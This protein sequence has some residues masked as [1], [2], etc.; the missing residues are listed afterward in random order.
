MSGRA[1]GLN[2]IFDHDVTIKGLTYGKTI[3]PTADPDLVNKKYVDDEILSELNSKAWLQATNQTGLTGDKSGSFNISTTVSFV[4]ASCGCFVAKHG[5]RSI[6]SKSGSAD[7][8]EKLGINL[9]LP[10]NRAVE[11][12]ENSGFVFMFAQ[13]HHPVM[14]HIMPIRKSISHR[15]IFN[16]LG[17]LTNPAGVKKQLIGV[18]DKS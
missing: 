12:L 6:T 16:I 9:N 17:P 10:P 5:N 18:F 3:T 8:L 1:D 2:D 4:L 7:V 14:K 13:N 11:L 15:T